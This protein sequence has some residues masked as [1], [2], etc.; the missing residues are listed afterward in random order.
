MEI[1]DGYRREKKQWL[2]RG[3]VKDTCTNNKM[4]KKTTRK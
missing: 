2:E 1:M 3:S 4:N